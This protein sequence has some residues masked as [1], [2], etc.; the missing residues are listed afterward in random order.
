M[1]II[2]TLPLIALAALSTVGC[3]ETVS[4]GAKPVV[5]A[6][7]APAAPTSGPN[8]S[9]ASWQMPWQLSPVTTASV[10]KGEETV[11]VYVPETGYVRGTRVAVASIGQPLRQV[12]GPNRTV[13]ACRD[14]V[15]SEAS[16]VGAK[17]VEAV[18]AGPQRRDRLGR[19][20]APVQ[21]RITY[22]RLGEYEVREAR[23]MCIV[24]GRGK[25]VDAYASGQ[26]GG[27]SS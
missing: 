18:S 5:V 15:R 6:A 22:A 7:S 19:F 24:D 25:I 17:E 8:S 27:R 21:M 16:K 20:I 14:V 4:S 23:L 3:A 26:D 9:A 10:E 1:K 11:Q 13:D 2:V 12:P